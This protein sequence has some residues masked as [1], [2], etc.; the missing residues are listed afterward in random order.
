MWIASL[1]AHNLQLTTTFLSLIS[2]SEKCC[3]YFQERKL[4]LSALSA[5]MWFNAHWLIRLV[6]LFA[7]PWSCDVRSEAAKVG[8]SCL[9]VSKCS[10]F[11]KESNASN[12]LISISVIVTALLDLKKILRYMLV[13]AKSSGITNENSLD[14]PTCTDGSAKRRSL[15]ERSILGVT[16]ALTRAY[17]WFMSVRCIS[18]YVYKLLDDQN[19]PRD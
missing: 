17:M 9:L 14:C 10:L 18:V 6:Y 15:D 7:P 4:I 12:E 16:F 5:M 1:S 8:L 11:T 3:P 19:F 2:T 13:T